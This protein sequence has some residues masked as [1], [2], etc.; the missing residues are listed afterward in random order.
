MVMMDLGR[1]QALPIFVP[2]IRC[3]QQ[4]EIGGRTLL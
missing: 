2:K 3:F 4:M 1:A